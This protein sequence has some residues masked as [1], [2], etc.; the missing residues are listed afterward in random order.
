MIDSIVNIINEAIV[1]DV[2][3]KHGWAQ[4]IEGK[5]YVHVG[6]GQWKPVAED[7]DGGWSY[8]RQT[9]M[10]GVNSMDLMG[11]PCGGVGIT[12]PLRYCAMMN[13]EDCGELPGLLVGIAG[14]IRGTSKPAKQLIAASSVDFGSIR[15]GIDEVYGQEFGTKVKPQLAK[16]FVN[17]DMIVT[18]TGS[19]SCLKHC[20]NV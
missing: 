18:V 20:R 7:T 8:I 11:Q 9:G 17:L 16:V 3:K 13:R 14:V 12:I 6:A 5:P 2:Q 1:L 4:L 10:I 15:I 19:E